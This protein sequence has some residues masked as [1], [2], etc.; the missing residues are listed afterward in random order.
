[1]SQGSTSS[2]SPQ[3]PGVPPASAPTP[4]NGPRKI[5]FPIAMGVILIGL[6]AAAA[7]Y[8]QRS[9]APPGVPSA[10]SADG[11]AAPAPATVDN[12]KALKDE[13]AALGGKL[14][15]LRTQVE[16]MPKPH[17]APDLG[18][19]Q[20]KV[21]DLATLPTVVSPLSKQVEELSTRVGTMNDAL[22]ALKAEVSSIQ[23][24]GGPRAESAPSS[25]PEKPVENGADFGAALKSEI[26][27]FRQGNYSQAL[28]AFEKLQKQHPDDARVWYYSALA[29][30]LTTGKWDGKTATL[31]KEGVAREKAGTPDAAQIDAEFAGL[32]KATGKEWLDF[33]RKQTR[34]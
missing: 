5:L 26:A 28:G 8:V 20:A 9:A 19:L 29:N 10:S 15:G 13:V 25:N 7:W 18:P 2:E 17:P 32:T 24:G 27:S 21:D 23:N 4:V 34:R 16:S 12:L 11:A 22:V 30:G 33:Y 6:L 14:D 1:M 3:S 31:V